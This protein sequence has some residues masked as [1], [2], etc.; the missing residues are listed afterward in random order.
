MIRYENKPCIHFVVALLNDLFGI[1]ERGGC[2]CAGPYGH[3][4]LG[5]DLTTSHAFEQ[6]VLKGCEGIKPGWAR[7]NFN[8]FISEETFD[9]IIEAVN[10]VANEGWRLLPDYEFCPMS[11]Q[12]S[13]KLKTKQSVMRLSDIRYRRG[14]MSYPS[15][16]LTAPEWILPEYLDAA[17]DVFEAASTPY[18]P[19]PQTSKP[20][21]EELRWFPLPFEVLSI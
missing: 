21:F 2:S 18:G 13:H 4:L 8:Y 5:I 3:R 20:E 11:G 9:Y 19:S 15:R 14:R 10:M 6:E 12:W 1:Q 17:R 16:K 7:V